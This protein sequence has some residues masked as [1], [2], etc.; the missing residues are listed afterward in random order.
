MSVSDKA[1]KQSISS[2]AERN[3]KQMPRSDSTI[4]TLVLA[5][6]AAIGVAYFVP[7]YLAPRGPEATTIGAAVAANT[8]PPA[9][10]DAAAV[11]RTLWVASAPG[12]V[13]PLGGEIR[14]TAQIPGRIADVMVAINDKV[15]AG[16][17]LVRLDDVDHEIRVN[18]AEAEAS[19]RRKDRDV[20]IARGPSQERRNAD[21]AVAAAERLLANNRA[22]FDRWLR[23]RRAGQATEAEVTNVRNMVIA[24]RAQL[25]AA[26]TTLRKL[27]S[28]NDPV[29]PAQT[30]LEAALSAARAEVAL[31]EST[32][33]KAHIR[34]PKSGTVLQVQAVAG[35]NVMPSPDQI[36]VTIGDL[37]SLRVRAELEERD[38]GKVRIGQRAVVRS[39]AFPGRDFDGV[40]SS[41]AQSLGSG[42]LSQKAPR[43]L[44][45]VDVLEFVVDLPVQTPLIPGMR[46]DV[47]LKPDAAAGVQNKTN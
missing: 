14:I 1:L 23:A 5:A 29:Q 28:S 45:D 6:V 41:M 22:E 35:E 31:A 37:S 17:L 21:D 15:I 39:D 27:V 3:G 38:V 9:A 7:R 47:L 11:S 24:A 44:S 10:A 2:H 36:L 16:D 25:D 4:N 12:R 26:R 46:V 42:R 43:K 19:T 30:R 8:T 34:A 20:E 40:V 32:F 33:E 13:E 18:A